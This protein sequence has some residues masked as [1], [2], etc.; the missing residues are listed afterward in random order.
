MSVCPPVCLS[1]A[2][3]ASKRLNTFSNFFTSPFGSSTILVSLY[4]T[5]WQYFDE[6]SPKGRR[7]QGR[8]IETT[9]NADNNFDSIAYPNHVLFKQKFGINTFVRLYFI[10]QQK[11][12]WIL[13]LG[14]LSVRLSVVT[15]LFL[16]QERRSSSDGVSRWLL[17]S[18]GIHYRLTYDHHR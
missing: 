11:R 14:V 15:C 8:G 12:C 6:D 7:I 16:E 10:D 3:I 17:R 13:L 4:Q 18:S 9:E 5:L 2:G 1:H